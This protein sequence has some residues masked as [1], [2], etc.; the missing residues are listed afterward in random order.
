METVKAA[1]FDPHE[2]VNRFARTAKHQGFRAEPIAEID[3]CP[4]IAL[5]RRT[6]GPR[7][8]IYLSSGVHGDEPAAPLALLELLERGVFDARAVWFLV[9]MLNPSGFPRGL[10][11]NRAGIDLNRDYRNPASKEVS[12]HV[13][14]LEHQPLFDLSF[15]LHEDWESTGFYLYELNPLARAS[16]AGLIIDA[17]GSAHP[18]DHATEIDGRPAKGG[19]IRPNDD[20]ASRERWPE[21]VYLRANHTTLSYT[22]EA[23]SGFPL[24]ERVAMHVLAVE[25]ALN[26]FLRQ[27]GSAI[28]K[29]LEPNH[30]LSP[31]PR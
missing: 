7:P 22:L 31:R 21:A 4:L 2:L 29:S 10:R 24:A 5:T 6:A 17:V 11:E 15:C 20:P 30:R 23:P 14:W 19:I 25:T 27:S 18:I 28:Q 13:K 16:L 8:R 3:G 9:P 26:H 12:A 1:P